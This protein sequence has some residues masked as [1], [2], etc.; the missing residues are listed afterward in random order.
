MELCADR[1]RKILLEAVILQSRSF[2]ELNCANNRGKLLF[3]ENYGFYD[4]NIDCS[5]VAE[6]LIS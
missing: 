3:I 5:I 1:S 4:N 6:T 2:S